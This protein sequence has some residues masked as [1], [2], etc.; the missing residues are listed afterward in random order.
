MNVA[1]TIGLVPEIPDLRELPRGGVVALR[2]FR[3]ADAA[4][5]TAACQDEEIHRW[6]ATIPWPY[7]E[8]HARDW[9]ATH[10]DIRRSGTGVAFAVVDAE[11]DV[12]LGSLGI[13]Q[14]DWKQWSAHPGYWIARPNRGRGIAS[15]A[16][17]LGCD[18]LH[19][20]VGFTCFELVT[21][22]GNRAS[23]RV[24]EKAGFDNRG[25]VLGYE[26]PEARGRRFDVTQWVLTY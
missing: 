6:T 18:W 7:E 3:D 22:L 15:T 23:E 11:S 20:V 17:I 5:V 25:I 4:A 26:L 21:M 2:W 10:E 13:G 14:L 1:T 12:L 9:I 24:A 19:R 8:Q 16:L